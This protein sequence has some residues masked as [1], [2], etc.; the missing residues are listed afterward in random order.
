MRKGWSWV[1]AGLLAG[2]LICPV[3]AQEPDP[4]EVR[5][6]MDIY[7]REEKPAPVPPPAPKPA[8]DYDHEAWKSAEKCG[9]AACFEAYLEDYPKGRYARMAKA[10]LKPKTEPKPKSEPAAP[11]CRGDAAARTGAA[12]ND[13]PGA[14]AN[15]R[16]LFPDGQS[17]IGNRARG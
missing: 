12:K 10:R 6:R 8:V 2:V 1:G 17:G 9:T 15:Q 4:E 3:L 7:L 5:R 11:A 14:D 16:R 13:R